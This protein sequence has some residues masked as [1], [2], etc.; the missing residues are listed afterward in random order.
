MSDNLATPTGA[1]PTLPSAVKKP[2]RNHRSAKKAGSSFETL[3]AG[4]LAIRLGD[5][6]IERRARNGAKDRGDI[7][8]VLTVRG[9]RV[10]I[11]CKNVTSTALPAW[12]R[13]AEV[14]RGNDDAAIGVVVH[15]RH[16]SARPDEQFVT[17]SLETFAHL[18]QGGE[19]L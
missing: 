3:V 18:L 15:K 19:A 7:A 11:E 9:G 1:A 13:E 2:R 14:E 5:E 16:G 17:M 8:G 10:V 6:R 4:F 12:L